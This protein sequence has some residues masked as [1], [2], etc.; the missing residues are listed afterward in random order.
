M[1]EII[2]RPNKFRPE[3]RKDDTMPEMS[4]AAEAAS[5]AIK[6]DLLADMSGPQKEAVRNVLTA[7][8]NV[9]RSAGYKRIF[10]IIVVD[11]L[12]FLNE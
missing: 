4:E 3:N 10:G 6:V 7:L 1:S 11:I 5:T 2:Q 9:V 8:R 12:N